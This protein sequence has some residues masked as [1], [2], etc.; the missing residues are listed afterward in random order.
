MSTGSSRQKLRRRL[1]LL[2]PFRL[3]LFEAFG[4]VAAVAGRGGTVRG[5]PRHRR[6]LR[7]VGAWCASPPGF[8]APFGPGIEPRPG[9]AWVS[10]RSGTGSAGPH[11]GEP[12]PSPFIPAPPGRSR[13][14]APSSLITVSVSS[15]SAQP[16]APCR[17]EGSPG[18][19]CLP[20]RRPWPCPPGRPAPG[21][22]L[23]RRR[24]QGEGRR[25]RD[26]GTACHGSG[27]RGRDRGPRAEPR[28]LEGIRDGEIREAVERA[29]R[30]G[31]PGRRRRFFRDGPA[32]RGRSAAN[33]SR[34]ESSSV[35]ARSLP[36]PSRRD[37]D[38]EPQ[39]GR[40]VPRVDVGRLGQRHAV[41]R[42]LARGVAAGHVVTGNADHALD[43]VG[44]RP[45][46]ADEARSRR[47]R[48]WRTS[49]PAAESAGPTTRHR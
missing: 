4:A 49:C 14:A 43:V 29:R 38:A 30:S 42:H 23:R 2:P 21:S 13:R 16:I 26:R 20:G 7:D 35:V 47:P 25:A 34:S 44:S 32:G 11:G 18:L 3:W 10:S 1:P 6:H 22:G 9:I 8:L 37:G 41:D 39:V 28:L 36:Q 27:R 31:T 33:G 15:T 17:T 19:S 5:L 45:G 48:S 24:R 46:D 12:K 40:R